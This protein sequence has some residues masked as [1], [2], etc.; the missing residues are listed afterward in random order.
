[1]QAHPYCLAV[2]VHEG[3]LKRLL[4]EGDVGAYRDAHPWYVAADLLQDAL[5]QEQQLYLL[6][7]T[8]SPLRLTHWAEITDIEVHSMAT[9]RETRVRLGRTGAVSPLFEEA[10]SVA[11]APS[12]WQ[13]ERERRE[14]LR[15]RRVHLDASWLRPYAVCETPA[16]LLQAPAQAASRD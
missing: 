16:F 6:L 3:V 4:E 1:M 12:Q 8:G 14:G 2:A 11:L 5:E 13:L 10:E 15:V 7:A 9:T